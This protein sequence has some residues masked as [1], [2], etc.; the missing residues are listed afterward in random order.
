MVGHVFI[1]VHASGEVEVHAGYR[2]RDEGHAVET[3]DNGRVPPDILPVVVVYDTFGAAI[4]IDRA[5]RGRRC[6]ISWH[7]G[8][9]IGVEFI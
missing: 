3:T 2:D 4:S 7:K 1:D 8:R 6:K 5:D 9:L